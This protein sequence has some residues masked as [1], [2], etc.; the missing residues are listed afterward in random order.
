MCRFNDQ[1][2]DEIWRHGQTVKGYDESKIRKDACGAWIIRDR[3]GDRT[4]PF[5]WEVDHIYPESKLRNKNVLPEL[6][7]N[8]T[9]LRPLNWKNNDSKGADYPSYQACITSKDDC[10][11]EG[12]YQYT[13]NDV[14]RNRVEQL[15]QE[16]L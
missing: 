1:L 3:Y 16:Y 10:N 2:L 15:Y 9:N 7:D 13:V 14:T 12:V 8:P 6:I 11:I 5:G 4:S